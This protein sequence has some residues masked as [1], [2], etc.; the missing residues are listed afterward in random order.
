[1]SQVD[2]EKIDGVSILYAQHKTDNRGQFI[3]FYDEE[4][5]N[6]LA[7]MEGFSS[8]AYSI[9][10]IAG[11]IRGLHFQR[12]S[13]AEQKLVICLEGSIFDVVVDLRQ[14]SPT[15][16]KWA[17]IEIKAQ[18]RVSLLLP[19]G[20]A[21]GFQTLEDNTKVLYGLSTPYRSTD[22]FSLNPMDASLKINWPQ[23]VKVISE[24]D[25]NGLAFDDAIHICA[26]RETQ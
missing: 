2:F 18:D 22:S 25:S 5:I 11:S 3:K 7:K 13:S 23:S 17:K 26:Q 6:F 19:K 14:K 1:M 15:F 24:K 21:H 9:T 12:S 16:R 10:E 8:I 20:L 4:S